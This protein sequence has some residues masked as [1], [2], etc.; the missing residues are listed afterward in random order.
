MLYASETGTTAELAKQLAYEL[1]RRNTR[2]SVM[3]M[4]DFDVADLPTQRM[5]IS[6][7]AT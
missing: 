3:A 4:D 1:K 5:V 6:L 7:A 2:V